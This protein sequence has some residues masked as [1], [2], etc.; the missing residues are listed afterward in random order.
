[1]SFRFTRP[2]SSSGFCCIGTQMTRLG[3][4]KRISRLGGFECQYC[5]YIDTMDSLVIKLHRKVEKHESRSIL[6]V[7][8][9]RNGLLSRNLDSARPCLFIQ[10]G[11]FCTHLGRNNSV[12]QNIGHFSPA[13]DLQRRQFTLLKTIS[14][15]LI[16]LR[17]R[18]RICTDYE[19]CNLH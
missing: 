1:M 5:F 4:L 12:E 18:I 2:D 17:S 9:A 7:H 6:T 11:G 14:H 19:S 16:I 10:L 15:P 3:F 13:C 8:N